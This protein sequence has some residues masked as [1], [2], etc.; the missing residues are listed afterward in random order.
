MSLYSEIKKYLLYLVGFFCLLLG[1]HVAVL[2]LYEGATVY[3]LPG[4][5]VNIGVIGEAPSLDILSVD[6]KLENDTNDMVFRFLYRGMLKYSLDDKRIVG[7]L[8]HCDIDTF[9]N[10]RCTLNQDALWNDGRAIDIED[11]LATYTLFKESSHNESTK[12]RLSVV[13]VSEDRGD[14]I[15]RFN[16]HDITTLDILFLPIIR[17]K[18]AEGLR[19]NT[20]FSTISFN[21]PYIFA[22]KNPDSGAVILKKNP[23]YRSIR[24]K[25]FLDQVRFGFGTSKKEVKKSVDPDVWLGD[26][27]DIGSG[28]LQQKYS[29]P[30]LS[31]IYLNAERIPKPL[32]KALFSDVF[33]TLEFNKNNFIPKENVFLGEIQ[34]SPRTISAEPLFSSAALLSGYTLGGVTPVPAPTV[35]AGP[36]Y[37]SLKYVDQPGRVSPLF[38]SADLIELKGTAPVGTT[39]VI[40]NDYTLQGF[41]PRNRIFIYKARKEFKNLNDGENLYKIQFFAGLK[42]LAEEKVMVLYNSNTASLDAIKADWIKKNTPVAEP[43]PPPPATLDPNKLYDKNGKILEFSLLVQ[44]DVPLFQEVASKIQAKLATLPVN[45]KVEFLPLADIQKIVAGQNPTYDIVL[46]G[47]NLG[48][49]HYNI[50]PFFH[51]GQIKN[52]FNISRIR[53]ASLDSL[54]EKLIERLYYNSPDKLRNI[55]T[56][57]QKILE[58]E[59][60]IFPLGTPEESWY[61]KNYVLGVTSSS[62]FSGKEMISD[63]VTKSYFKEGYKR[64]SEAKTV[65]GFFLWLK[66]ALFSRT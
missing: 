46:A 12:S 9:P 32:R 47:V 19:E 34:N 42:L 3:P 23:A 26:V 7:D 56:E 45:V 44:S 8:A 6:T 5:T 48:V 58:S 22:E 66:N 11:V 60:I 50:M 21:G 35:P 55:E 30:V 31:S 53:N 51:S 25:Y 28:F 43:P 20:N 38:L 17:G 16:T 18:D 15:F 36:S 63:L 4:G 57:I 37:T 10:V 40:V 61:I 1:A 65:S 41:I 52:G 33:N 24:D 62:F 54:T 39:K 2:Y 64:S 59:S 49:F 27:S 14:I 29:R 13:D